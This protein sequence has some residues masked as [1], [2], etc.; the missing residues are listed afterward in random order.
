MDAKDSPSA[1]KPTNFLC[2]TPRILII[3]KQTSEAMT[4]NG[5]VLLSDGNPNLVEV[6]REPPEKIQVNPPSVFCGNDS[7]G[8]E[9]EDP[10]PKEGSGDTDGDHGNVNLEAT[11]GKPMEEMANHDHNPLP[12][13][14]ENYGIMTW[15]DCDIQ[16]CKMEWR[17]GENIG[18]ALDWSGNKPSTGCGKEPSYGCDNGSPESNDI[19]IT[20]PIVQ[21]FSMDYRWSPLLKYCKPVEVHHECVSED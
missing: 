21:Q 4:G 9:Q 10:T 8:I 13:A 11:E 19:T 17:I 15:R 3:R 16:Q 18:A 6:E 14:N 7:N 12:T 20:R 2:K 1:T 5:D